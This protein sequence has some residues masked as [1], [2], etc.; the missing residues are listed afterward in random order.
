[1]DIS[2][3]A[4]GVEGIDSLS[5]H[6]IDNF[7]ARHSPVT[8]DDCHNMAEIITGGPVS[9]TPVQGETSYTVAAD[10]VPAKV[11]QFRQLM[12]DLDVINRARQTY[13]SFVPSCE[14]RSKLAHLYVYEMD[15]VPGVALSRFQHQL[16]APRMKQQLLRTVQDLARFVNAYPYSLGLPERFRQKLGEIR[17]SLPLLFRPEYIMVINHDD[18]LEMNI[19]VDEETGQI[20]GIVDWTDAKI[21]PFGTSLWGLETLLG[22]QTSSSWLF[23]P[24]H[25][26]FRQK[27]WE[28]FYGVTGEVL[29]IDRQAIEIGRMFGLFRA[30]GFNGAPENKEAKPL[31]EGDHGLVYL[32]AL[33]LP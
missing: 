14:E 6:Q 24:D 3:Y 10:I 5:T 26:Y 2:I 1:M 33:C 27:F 4:A 13:R 32:E 15:L 28:T 30:Y 31:K 8:K 21:A 19:H 7:F 29:D 16:F 18:L 12:L 9:P 22:I 25:H 17:Q 23:H 20:T 11:I